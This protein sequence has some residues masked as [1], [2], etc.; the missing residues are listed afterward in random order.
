M[1]FFEDF[2]F[3]SSTG[4][5]EIRARR[6]LPEGKVRAVVQIEHGI[7]EHIERYDDFMRALAEH[8]YLAVGDDHLGHGQSARDDAELGFF[9]ERDGWQRITDDMEKL[10]DMTAAQYPEVPY[11]IF[12]HSM[13]S[14]LART[15]LIQ[16]PGKYDAA[17]L[18]GTGWPA[19]LMTLGGLAVAELAV[20]KEGARALGTKLNDIAFGSYC[21]RI[22]SPRTPFDW[23]SR[24]P[25]NVDR[26]ISDP[27]CGF[28]AKNA[29]Y[30]DMLTGIRY[31]TTAANLT[32][33]RKEAPV[34]FLSGADDPVGDY[35]KGVERAYNAFCKAGMQ[36][37]FL[38]LYPEGRH[39][40]LNELNRDEVIAD[41]LAWLDEKVKT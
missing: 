30:R 24:V 25:E 21:K 3:P 32:Q 26:Y 4:V 23:L 27:K 36:D 35:G 29:L 28:V 14:F 7:A 13:G 22:A 15:F 5:N 6:C 39:E 12:G 40:M 34:F 33:M 41:I 19:S 38:R 31:I 18:S 16:R 10:H 8:G 11:V 2:R 20:R 17:I 1:V 9:A 37:V